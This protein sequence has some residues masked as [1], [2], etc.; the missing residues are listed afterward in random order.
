MVLGK[1]LF[2]IWEI[3]LEWM[4]YLKLL[5]KGINVLIYFFFNF[6]MIYVMG[7]DVVKLC[8]VMKVECQKMKDFFNEGMDVGV[9]GFVFFYQG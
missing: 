9:L 3:F 1:V 2:W 5:F 6:L 7:V 8:L 4:V